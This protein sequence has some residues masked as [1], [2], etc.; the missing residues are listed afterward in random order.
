MPSKGH[1]IDSP[2]QLQ[3]LAEEDQTI[4][5]RVH[6]SLLAPLAH[7][8]VLTQCRD[9]DSRYIRTPEGKRGGMTNHEY[10]NIEPLA[11][12]WR[13][14][15]R[16]VPTTIHK[17]TFDL[18]LP[19]PDDG[20]EQVRWDHLEG[21]ALQVHATEQATRNLVN[22]LVLEMHMRS[23]GRVKMDVMCK[24]QGHP[25][26]GMVRSYIE[27]LETGGRSSREKS[28]RERTALT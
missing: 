12:A 23:H 14:S 8:E 15:W 2:G 25:A 28:L 10:L 26:F 1:F 4:E 19:L 9:P 21:T 17:V 27:A 24:G 7:E 22:T 3:R 20:V 16:A 6:I 11:K 13:Q 5:H 18:S